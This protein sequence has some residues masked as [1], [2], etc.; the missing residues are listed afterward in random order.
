MAHRRAGYGTHGLP[1]LAL[2]TAPYCY[3]RSLMH[4]SHGT[5][6]RLSTRFSRFLC[7]FCYPRSNQKLGGST[8]GCGLGRCLSHA[9]GDS[10]GASPA[11]GASLAKSRGHVN[12]TV[13]AK[14]SFGNPLLWKPCMS[15]RA[16]FGS[17]PFEQ[18]VLSASLRRERRPP[19][20][21]IHYPWL[22]SSSQQARDI[23]RFR[24]F[25]NNHLAVD[26]EDPFLI[27]DAAIH[28]FPMK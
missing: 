2:P 24:W 20:H 25:S 26:K 7:C 19:R 1:M 21:Q 11:A 13:S 12:A 10:R 28:T 23:E 4:E 18:A 16:G 5:P 14:P 6:F 22:D 8:L 27:V 17:M 9:R 3:G 15:T